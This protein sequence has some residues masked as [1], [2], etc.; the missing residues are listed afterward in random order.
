LGTVSF[1]T[2]RH[3]D[4]LGLVFAG[5]AVAADFAGTAVG[6]AKPTDKTALTCGFGMSG[7]DHDTKATACTT[8]ESVANLTMVGAVTLFMLAT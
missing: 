6:A 2:G 1:L 4:A 5:D 3:A 7:V 8:S